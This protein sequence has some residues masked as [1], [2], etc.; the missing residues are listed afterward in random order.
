MREVAPSEPVLRADDVATLAYAGAGRS[1]E[2]EIR[3]LADGAVSITVPPV[4]NASRTVGGVIFALMWL[5]MFALLMRATGCPLVAFFLFGGTYALAV[6]V[7]E[8][9][10]RDQPLVIVATPAEIVIENGPWFA[11]TRRIPRSDIQS[12]R[13]EA[14]GGY[15]RFVL[16]IKTKRSLELMADRETDEIE[17]VAD[18]LNTVGSEAV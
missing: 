4:H 10:R 1:H 9:L 14:S 8:Y 7:R 18:A 6:A 17:C 12:I 11:P 2:V 16:L 15:R 3:R 5:V 13:S